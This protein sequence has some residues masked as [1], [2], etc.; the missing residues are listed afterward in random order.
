MTSTFCHYKTTYLTIYHNNL[1]M[2]D[3]T[4]HWLS[5]SNNNWHYLIN[6]DNMW[7]YPSISNN[8]SQKYTIYDKIC[9]YLKNRTI[10]DI[11]LQ[12][13]KISNNILQYLTINVLQSYE[14]ICTTS[15]DKLDLW[16]LWTISDIISQYLTISQNMQQ[17]LT[18]SSNI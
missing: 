2:S 14:I 15:I 4:E 12:Y 3:I 6:P 5:I 17:H 8:S 13:L 16:K 11:E 7:L 18:I 9:Q 10:S 1:T